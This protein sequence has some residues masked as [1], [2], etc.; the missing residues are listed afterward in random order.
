MEG[1]RRSRRPHPTVLRRRAQIK[2]EEGEVREEPTP[3]GASGGAGPTTS[4]VCPINAGT[5][6]WG[7]RAGAAVGRV[8]DAP[9]AT[10]P[11][12]MLRLRLLPLT[13]AARSVP[14]QLRVPRP[15]RKPLRCPRRRWPAR[16]SRRVGG[17][18]WTGSGA[19][20]S[21]SGSIRQSPP[22]EVGPRS[23][24]AGHRCRDVLLVFFVFRKHRNRDN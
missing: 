3:P 12:S 16:W 11:A 8:V 21:I 7:N 20:P 14:A 15:T 2:A 13:Q 23:P 22:R 4:L 5:G 19:E 24:Q 18:L 9:F 10:R 6:G 17:P 1:A